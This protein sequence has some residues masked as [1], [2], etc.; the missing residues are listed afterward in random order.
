M[1]TAEETAEDWDN[2]DNDDDEN[3]DEVD[4]VRPSF[5]AEVPVYP[6]VALEVVDAVSQPGY[7]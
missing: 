5:G 1:L 7:E 2:D 4:V 3:Q 6:V